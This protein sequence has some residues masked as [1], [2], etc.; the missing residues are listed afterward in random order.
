MS[1]ETETRGDLAAALAQGGRWLGENPAM[2]E[3]QAAEIL[4]VMPGQPEAML[5]LAR[6]RRRRSGPAAAMAVLEA[7]IRARPNWAPAHLEAGLALWDLGEPGA[8]AAAAARAASLEPSSPRVWRTLAEFRRACGDE[9]GAAEAEAGEIRASAS[10][11]ALVEAANA[12]AENRLPDAEARLQAYLK[13]AAGNAPALRMLAEAVARRGRLDE[14]E[15]LLVRCLELSPGFDA[16][17]ANLA[18]VLHRQNRPAEAIVEIDRLL[19]KD[20]TRAGWRTLKAAALGRI[21]EY[22]EAIA[23]YQGLLA[24]HPD[25]PKLWMSCGHA[26]KTVGRTADCIAAYRQAVE[27]EPSLGE[28]WWSLANLKTFRFADADVAV[29]ERELARPDISDEDRLHLDFA[30]GKAREDAQDWAGAFQAFAR[31]AALRRSQVKYDPEAVSDHRRRSETLFTAEF[32]RAREGWG[33][34]APDPIFV[35]GL[36]RSGSTLIEQILASHSQVEGTM[37]LPDVIAMARRIGGGTHRGPESLYPEALADLD[38]DGLRALGEEYLDRTR[39]QRKTGRPFFIDKMPNNF[40]HTGL[41]ALMLPNAK[42]VD[43]RRHPM[44]CCFSAFK[45]HFARGQA[46]TYDLEEL[47]RYWADYAGLMDH[48]DRVMPGRVHRVHYEAMVADTEGE[49]RRLL[50]YCGLPFEDACLRF[51][52]NDRAVR[53]ASSEQVRRPIY[54]ESVDHWRNFEPFLEPLRRALGDRVDA[55][56]YG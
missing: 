16:A 35:V 39:I 25:Q 17:R 43:A 44:G 51:H 49:T 23:L 4:K 22:E 34:A 31:G 41:I 13:H 50:E 10:D 26:L 33:C 47:G 11:P 38:A 45:Q 8:A 14:A 30:L 42:I 28:A 36:P 53:T 6:A 15:R 46:F 7:L 40:A 20:P 2:A 52:E 27:R 48:F 19:A 3:A 54:G 32:M 55:Y 18:T 56:P 1:T 24:E 21:G 5:L 29:L 12:L 37:E 9:A